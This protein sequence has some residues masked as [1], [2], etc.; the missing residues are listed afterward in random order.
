MA[1]LQFGTDS[2]GKEILELVP[3]TPAAAP[4]ET[5]DVAKAA[6]PSIGERDQDDHGGA[7][8][9]AIETAAAAAGLGEGGESMP[10]KGENT[11]VMMEWEKPYMRALVDALA[12]TGGWSGQWF[13]RGEM[14]EKSEVCLALVGV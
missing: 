13:A 4:S 9:G 12:I 1:R 5:V 6:A 11:I 2:L 14:E 3:A 10:Y 8:G 7:A